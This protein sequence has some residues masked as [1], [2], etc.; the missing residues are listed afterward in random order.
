[1][2]NADQQKKEKLDGSTYLF[3]II[4]QVEASKQDV[5]AKT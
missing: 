2:K 4:S 5:K 3:F 1:M